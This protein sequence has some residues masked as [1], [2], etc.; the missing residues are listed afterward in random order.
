[1]AA[2]TVDSDGLK[3]DSLRFEA[4]LAATIGAH[5]KNLL[6]SN[7]LG[8]N[9]ARA[10]LRRYLAP[11]DR[12]TLECTQPCATSSPCSSVLRTTQMHT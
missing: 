9:V 2:Q 12:H 1:M 8:S 4:T 10:R 3:L 6:R 5:S 11:R 7:G